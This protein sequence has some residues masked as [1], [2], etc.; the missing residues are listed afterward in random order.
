MAPSK[1]LTITDA[2]SELLD[3]GKIQDCLQEF[4]S[5]VIANT[6]ICQRKDD[7]FLLRYLYCTNFKVEDAFKRLSSLY[8]L[9]I[10]NMDWFA[11]SDP[12]EY[13]HILAWHAKAILAGRDKFGRRIYYT[14]IANIDVSNTNITEIARLDDLWLEAVLDEPD[15]Q[16]N[17]LC[18]M[19]DL[20]GLSWKFFPWFTP[21]NLRISSRKTE[22]LPTKKLVI[23]VV[24]SS[25]LLNA[26]VALTFP[27]L[28]E[29]TKENIHFHH[30]DWPSLHKFIDPENLPIEYGGKLTNL[31]FE[32]RNKWLL[33]Q[34]PRL[35]ENFKNDCRL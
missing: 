7:A 13:S 25:M 29:K 30:E 24:R 16:I 20:E 5:L 35:L 26:A 11:Q 8:E 21:S 22:L 27:F 19:V 1:S 31:D 4:R 15:T 28:S 6:K 32:D 17:G 12:S 34:G 33:E 10:E 14:K 3:E 23:H 9:R 2:T 18:C